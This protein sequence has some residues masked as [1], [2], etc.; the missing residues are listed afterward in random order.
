MTS[1]MTI[2]GTCV[3]EGQELGKRTYLS[4]ITVRSTCPGC[5]APYERDLGY[6]PLSY[7]KVGVPFVL[8][9]YCTQCSHEWD[10]GTVVLG[11]TLT[12]VG[13]DETATG[14]VTGEN[15][16]RD[17]VMAEIGPGS[18]ISVED[19]DLVLNALR[20]TSNWVRDPTQR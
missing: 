7:P 19:V 2:E 20:R 18:R 14:E 11:M 13:T 12:A 4:G 17:S 8:H 1:N 6:S 5:G 15:T 3:G 9:G 16:L 10:V